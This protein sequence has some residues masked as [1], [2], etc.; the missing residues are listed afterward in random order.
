MKKSYFAPQTVVCH[1]VMKQ[2]IALSNTLPVDNSETNG[3]DDE[4]DVLSRRSK[5]LWDDEE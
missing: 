3:V 4:D 5:S 2:M 1:I